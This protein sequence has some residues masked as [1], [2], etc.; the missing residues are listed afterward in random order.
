MTQLAISR[1]QHR[2]VTSSSWYLVVMSRAATSSSF[3]FEARC[4][5]AFTRLYEMFALKTSS[6]RTGEI[7][8][9]IADAF[10]HLPHVARTM[11]GK[12]GS[13]LQ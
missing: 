9:A 11:D 10:K 6:R 4:V 8:S 1:S 3:N 2:T 13:P 12:S 5:N 7:C